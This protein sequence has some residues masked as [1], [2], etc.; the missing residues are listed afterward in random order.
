M[1]LPTLLVSLHGAPAEQPLIVLPAPLLQEEDASA[2]EW[3]GSVTLGASTSTGNTEVSSVTA[4]VDASR[5][6][7]AETWKVQFN[8]VFNQEQNAGVSTITQRRNELNLKYEHNLSERLYAYGT[9]GAMSDFKAQLDLRSGAG[10]GAGYKILTGDAWTLDGELGLTY[11]NEL[12]AEDAATGLQ[13]RNEYLA[14]HAG[15]LTQWKD[16][17]ERMKFSHRGDL[18]PAIDGGDDGDSPGFYRLDTTL[19]MNVT[20]SF[21]TQFQWLFTRTEVP[22]AGKKKNDNLFLMTVGWGF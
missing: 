9:A 1:M 6:T 12:F 10:A 14:A 3:E 15:Y 11:L 8:S 4:G 2:P 20:E 7:E 19:R 13:D 17:D 16:A 21:F 18:Y 5:A 22:Q